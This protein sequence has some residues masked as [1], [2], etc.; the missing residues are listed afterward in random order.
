MKIIAGID[1]GG[2]KCAVSFAECGKEKPE[3]L[4]KQRFATATGFAPTM[5]QFIQIITAALAQH[6]SWQ[7]AGIGI[8]CGGPLDSKRGLI[9]SPPNLPHWDGVDVI[10][11]LAEEFKV[12]VALQNDADACALAEWKWGAGQGTENMIFLTFGTGMGAGLILNGKLYVG[13]NNL[14]GEVGHVRL[15]TGGPLGYGKNGSFEGYCSGGGIANLGKEMARQELQRGNAPS[16]C[17]TL[18]ELESITA[19]SIADAMDEGDPLARQIYEITGEYLGRG[20]AVLVDILNPECIVLG[21]IY[22][23]QQKVLEPVMKKYLISEAI[24]AAYQN[25]KILPAYLGEMV[26]DYAALSVASTIL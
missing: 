1:I 24:P 2:T 6:S 15:S 4:E 19:K 9:L 18:E 12:P 16:F 20:L 23:R 22:V 8:S 26:G 21:S 10:T 7:L 5:E 3:I 17:P 11:P 25:C 13:F 14:A